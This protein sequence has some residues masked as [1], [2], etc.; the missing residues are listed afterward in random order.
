LIVRTSAQHPA[1][2]LERTRKIVSCG[3]GAA[4]P[5]LEHVSLARIGLDGCGARPQRGCLCVLASTLLQIREVSKG[6]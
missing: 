2:T 3:C 6:P 1:G 4:R 5:K